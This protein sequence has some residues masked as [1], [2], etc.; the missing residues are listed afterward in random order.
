MNL[1][2][3]QIKGFASY[4]CREEKRAATQEKYLR[5]VQAFCVYAAGNVITKELVA[6]WKKQLVERG[7]ANRYRAV[8]ADCKSKTWIR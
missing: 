5:H 2:I 6:A 3:E 4:L 1:S 8:T 7:Y